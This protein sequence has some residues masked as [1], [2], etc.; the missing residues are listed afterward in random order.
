MRTNEIRK[1]VAAK[2]QELAGIARDM[3][4]Q[5]PCRNSLGHAAMAQF[6]LEV[7]RQAYRAQNELDAG[8]EHPCCDRRALHSNWPHVLQS[9]GTSAPYSPEKDGRA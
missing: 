4:D 6:A 3:C 8:R 1:R 7:E 9:P 5:W 2:W